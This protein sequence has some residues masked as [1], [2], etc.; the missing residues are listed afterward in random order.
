MISIIVCSIDDYLYSNFIY[1]LK[2]TIGVEYEIIRINNRTENLDITIAYNKGGREAKFDYLLFVHE[3]VVFHTKYWGKLLIN[4]FEALNNPGVLGVV[5]SSYLPISPSDWWISNNRFLHAN[6][7]SNSKNGKTNEGL[8]RQIGPQIPQKVY[9]LDGMFL[10]MNKSTFSKYQ[11]DEELKGFHG[12]DTDICLQVSREFQNYFI[13]EI[14]IEH[15]SK[16]NPNFIWLRNQEIAKRKILPFFES[17]Y[18]DSLISKKAEV[19]AFHLFLGQ[20]YKYGNNRLENIT[21]A[22]FYLKQISLRAF[23][24]YLIPIFIKY[25]LVYIFF[26]KNQ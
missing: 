10:F 12:Y 23:S 26:S 1:S 6:Y 7:I 18:P 24:I 25:V 11:F 16:G 22:W 13:P 2:S 15:F 9:V 3:D 8:H 21:L 14:L 17:L 5:G 4:Y 19:L 20:L